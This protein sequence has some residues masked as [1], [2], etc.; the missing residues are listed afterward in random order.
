MIST[1]LMSP[2][3]GAWVDLTP[4]LRAAT[5][6]T[7]VQVDI[8]PSKWSVNRSPQGV[9]TALSSVSLGLG[10]HHLSSFSSTHLLLLLTVVL[11][12][13]ALGGLAAGG[14]TLLIQVT[15]TIDL[16]PGPYQYQSCSTL[17]PTCFFR[18]TGWLLSTGT[19]RTTL[20]GST[21]HFGLLTLVKIH[22]CQPDLQSFAGT[23]SIA[24]LVA[25]LTLSHLSYPAVAWIQV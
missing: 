9:T 8:F 17:P 2:Y 22:F 15:N 1:L 3:L 13:A 7:V 24:P 5:T 12:T 19:A 4:R 14:I 11:G 21:L 25:G 10:L 16:D 18:K 6:L 20:R 23:R